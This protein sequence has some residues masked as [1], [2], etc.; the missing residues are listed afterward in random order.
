MDSVI[1]RV[2]DRDMGRVRDRGR[3]R[4]L[5]IADLNR[6]HWGRKLEFAPPK[7]NPNH[8]PNPLPPGTGRKLW[9][10]VVGSGRW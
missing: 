4:G 3:L 10:V 2:R 8:I 5:A 1:D 7:S 9:S 6:F